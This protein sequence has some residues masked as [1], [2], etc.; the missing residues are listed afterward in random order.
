M[1]WLHP[2][3][4]S[5]PRL[6]EEQQRAWS[7]AHSD[8]R[9]PNPKHQIPDKFQSPKFEKTSGWSFE[10]WIWSLFGICL[11]AGR[12]GICDLGF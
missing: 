12:Q 11:P 9:E 1:H 3:C 7:I 5:H 8:M 10:I 4:E 6:F 2:D